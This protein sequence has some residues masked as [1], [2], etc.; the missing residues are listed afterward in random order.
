[1]KILKGKNQINSDI[2]NYKVSDVRNV[3]K[4]INDEMENLKMK[5]PVNPFAEISIQQ[6]I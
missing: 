6:L 1:M 3:I 2:V 5:N 4:K